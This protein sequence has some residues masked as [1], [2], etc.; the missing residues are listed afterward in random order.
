MH[1]LD[2]QIEITRR[3]RGSDIQIAIEYDEGLT[4]GERWDCLEEN[5]VD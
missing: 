2:I 1:G 3:N 4:R 5:A